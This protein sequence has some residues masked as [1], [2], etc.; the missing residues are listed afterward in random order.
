MRKIFPCAA[1][2]AA[3]GMSTAYPG[4]APSGV[5]FAGKKGEAVQEK[6][7]EKK[8]WGG[9]NAAGMS[10]KRFHIEEWGKHYSSVGSKR[11]PIAVKEGKEKKMFRSSTRRFPEKTYEMSRWNRDLADLQKRAQVDTDDR[12]MRIAE[13]RVYESAINDAEPFPERGEK[14]SLRDINRYQ[15]RRN[16]PEGQVPVERAGGAD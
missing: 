11:A 4:L 7:F 10:E 14:L 16:R 12:A 6:R 9:G 1:L 15:F 2:L 8:F 3:F 5:D 13:Q